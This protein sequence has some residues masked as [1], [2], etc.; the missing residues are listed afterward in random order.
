MNITKL[1]K[2]TPNDF[3]L[4]KKIREIFYEKSNNSNELY[5]QLIGESLFE[6]FEKEKS[7]I[8]DKYLRL[9]ADFENY[10]KRSQ[11]EKEDIRNLTKIETLSAVLDVDNDL[12]IAFE[13]L[14]NNEE[15]MAPTGSDG[16]SLV[17]SKV[18]KF[19]KS[20]GID[21]IQ[22]DIYDPSIHDVVS[23]VPGD[24]EKIIEVVSRGY[25]LNGKI[26]R[27]PKVIISK[28]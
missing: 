21:I 7:E 17:I 2:E 9:Y 15:F 27:Y 22:T 8:N 5:D 25:S 3:E 14:K 16:I 11:K 26:M 13:K 19:L 1:V 20:Q 6:E 23:I 28:N 24:E 4:G 18:S 10:K 12:S